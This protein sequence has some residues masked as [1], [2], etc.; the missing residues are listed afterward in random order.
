MR[1]VL[2]PNVL[3]LARLAPLGAPARIVRA[4]A[5]EQFELVISPELAREL[6]EVL[7]RKKFRR[8]LSVEEVT[9]Y[10]E[11]LHA[12][13]V[14]VDDP[15]ERPGVAAD[16]DD[17]YLLALAVAAGAEY[18]VSGDGHLTELEAPAVPVLTP[19]LFAEKIGV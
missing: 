5:Q 7:H 2:D 17:D 6:Q 19:R 15:V 4:W 3:I 10:I 18:L 9:A 14:A 1:V 12:G 16:P 13:A 11:Q 8:W